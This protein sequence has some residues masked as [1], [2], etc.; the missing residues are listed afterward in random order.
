MNQEIRRVKRSVPKTAKTLPKTVKSRRLEKEDSGNGKKVETSNE[1][2]TIEKRCGK[3]PAAK[4]GGQRRNFPAPPKPGSLVRLIKK[5]CNASIHCDIL[6]EDGN[7]KV[8]MDVLCDTG[9]QAGCCGTEF[10]KENGYT[11][12]ED[13]NTKLIDAS[14]N[15]MEVVGSV[16]VWIKPSEV[17]EEM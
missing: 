6:G 10:V 2:P 4:T 17:I 5:R 3:A 12:D 9:T 8:D 7:K 14:G 15:E 13:C 1:R 16:E 11:I